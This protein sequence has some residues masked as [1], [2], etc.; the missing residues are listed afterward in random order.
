MLCTVINQIWNLSIIFYAVLG[1]GYSWWWLP[2]AGDDDDDDDD[3]DAMM[4]LVSE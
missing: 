1:Y 4:L 3:T 2:D